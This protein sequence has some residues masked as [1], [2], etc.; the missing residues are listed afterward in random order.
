MEDDCMLVQ[1][2]KTVSCSTSEKEHW[3]WGG[4]FSV[5]PYPFDQKQAW[6]AIQ[7][8]YH[9]K[10]PRSVHHPAPMQ[11]FWKWVPCI[12]AH[13]E[14]LTLDRSPPVP[15]CH[16]Y[17]GWHLPPVY[18][19]DLRPPATWVAG[20]GWRCMRVGAAVYGTGTVGR[21]FRAHAPVTSPAACTLIIS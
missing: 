11:Y 8:G 7:P 20:A 13:Y 10:S 18:L 4:D 2:S 1:V 3:K 17:E 12:L 19:P 16:R 9:R 6:M 5:C 21:T 14:R 15:H